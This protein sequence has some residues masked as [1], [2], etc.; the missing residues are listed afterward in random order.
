MEF[1]ADLKDAPERRALIGK[2]PWEVPY[3]EPDE[4]VWRRHRETVNA[5]LPFRDFELA[6]F[7]SNGQYI[8]C[9]QIECSR[10]KTPGGEK[11]YASVSGLPV[12]DYDGNF[13]GYRGVAQRI[14]ERK[15]AELAI[16][17]SEQRFRTLFE[18]AND[19]IF[20]ENERDEIV[21]VNERAC[22]LLGYSREELL[23]MKVSDLQAPEM[24]DRAGSAVRRELEWHGGDTFEAVDLHRSGHRV[25]VEVT[26]TPIFDHGEKLVLSV[27]RDITERKRAAEVLQQ[28]QEQ[29]AHANRVATMG[30]LTA[31][32]AHEIAQPIGAV[33]NRANA[34]IN[35]LNKDPPDLEE[36]REA[37][38]R[39]A[40][41]ADR[42][43]EI[44]GRIRDQ[45]R[46]SAATKKYFRS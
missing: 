22:A 3:L 9:D 45:V 33:Y 19:A 32:I 34:A 18:K 23:K 42:A 37:I 20:L 29:L 24:R 26:N 31:S 40:D 4:E 8:K 35:F 21:E 30:Q 41:A 46:E 25:V 27:V 15:R 44:I 6:R 2:T 5:H 38:S 17:E 11:R 7:W 12:F 13:V 16:R 14:T 10:A 28:M 43:R 36:V 1:S 39:I